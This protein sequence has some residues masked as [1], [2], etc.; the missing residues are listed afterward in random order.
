MLVGFLTEGWD[1][2]VLRAYMARLWEVQE[3]DIEPDAVGGPGRNWSFVI[4]TAPSALRRVYARGASMAVIGIDNDG[5]VNLLNEGVSE[6]P[7]PRRHWLHVAHEAPAECRWCRL[8][9]VTDAVLPN[10]TW[11][12]P[13]S[14]TN[15]PVVIAVPVEC[16][17]IVAVD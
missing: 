14:G 13:R 12:A 3:S 7:N 9:S 11:M 10:L 2:L 6:D 4:K 5:G 16:I 15:W 1:Y 8:R 17:G